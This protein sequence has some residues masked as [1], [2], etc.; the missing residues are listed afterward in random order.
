LQDVLDKALHRLCKIPIK[1]TGN[2]FEDMKHF[3]ER[4]NIE[5]QIYKFVSRKLYKGN[6]NPIKVY[7]LMSES[8]YDVISNTAAFTCANVAH[9][10][11]RNSK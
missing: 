7:I 5:I 11:S 2:D 4:L 1:E 9:N 10:T 8:Q 3:E 6:E